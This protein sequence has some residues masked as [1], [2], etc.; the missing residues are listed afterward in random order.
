MGGSRRPRIIR[1]IKLECGCDKRFIT[2]Y[3]LPGES[4]ICTRH[5]ATKVAYNLDL[6]IRCLVCSYSR[7]CGAAPVTSQVKA[8]T[9]A[10]KYSHHVAVYDAENHIIYEID[11]EERQTSLDDIPPF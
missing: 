6:F 1:T 3:P 10:L 5:G 2:N 7:N 4:L 8:V 11:P 9:H